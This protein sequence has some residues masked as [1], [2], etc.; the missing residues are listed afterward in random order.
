[1]HAGSFIVSIFHQTLTW[2]TGS[3]SCVRDQ[4]SFLHMRVHTGVEH[5]DSKSAQHFWPGKTRKFCLGK[6][7]CWRHMEYCTYSQVSSWIVI[8]M[9]ACIPKVS[10]GTNKWPAIMDDSSGCSLQASACWHIFSLSPFIICKANYV[11]GRILSQASVCLTVCPLQT[12]PRKI[13][14]SSSSNLAQWLPQTW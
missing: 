4:W 10:C 7:R 6:S 9:E 11:Y 13:L 5:T 8:S 2:T 3:L 14:K 12:I 1:M